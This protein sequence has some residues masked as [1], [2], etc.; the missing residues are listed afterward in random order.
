ML[1]RRPADADTSLH[2][3]V[4]LTVPLV[5]AALLVIILDITERR[6][7]R[8][9]TDRSGTEGLSRIRK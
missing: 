1:S 3:T 2:N 8:Q 5:D 4:N 6:L 7:V 9:R